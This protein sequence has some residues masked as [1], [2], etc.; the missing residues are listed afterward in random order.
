MAIKGTV[1]SERT[2]GSWGY[3]GTISTNDSTL[4]AWQN[5]VNNNSGQASASLNQTTRVTELQNTLNQAFLDINALAAS[6][7][8]TRPVN[9]TP[10]S[11]NFSNLSLA[12]IN[13]LDTTNGT[14]ET[15]VINVTSW[16][17]SDKILITGDPGDAFIMRWDTDA[18]F[19]DG[20]EGLVKF[21]SGGGIVPLGGL[22]PSSFVHV[23]GAMDA[24]GG[25]TGIG[26][27][28]PYYP[29]SV[30]T[31][32]GFGAPIT[33][34][35]G[36]LD[37]GG[38]FTGYWLSTG[39][40][41]NAPDANHSVRWGSNGSFSNGIFIGGWYSIT[42]NFSM[43]SGTAGVYVGPLDYGDL[44][45]PKYNT[46]RKVTG[47]SG[48]GHVVTD[49]LFM[50]LNFAT[51]IDSE[52]DG[53]PNATATGDDI[54]QGSQIDDETAVTIPTLLAGQNAVF[55]VS[56]TNKTGGNATLYGFIDWNNDGDFADTGETATATVANNT[57]GNVPLTFSVP[58]GAVTGT[59]LGARFRLSTATGLQ[60]TD[61][62][63]TNG[64][65]PAPDG[66]VEDYLVTVQAQATLDFGD[67]PAAAQS[68]F[69]S[70]YPTTLANNGARHTASGPTLGSARD[71]E[72]DGQP[73]ANADGDDTTGTPDDEDGVT[74]P[75]LTQGQSAA[76][77]VNASAA[78]KLDAWIDWNRD[79]DWADAGEQVATNLSVE[80]GNN[81]L[82]V[83]VP[84]GAST[85]TSF[86]RFRLEHR[87]RPDL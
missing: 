80:A 60:A 25:G 7:T 56:V 30:R 11:L 86:A 44:A 68:G 77:T 20:Y 59:N 61:A 70:S 74:I 51:D 82:N 64:P 63:G 38:F 37:Q 58:A 16:P 57:L 87:G 47:T 76:L 78:A 9:G 1:A 19:S 32:N 62:Q 26:E 34:A 83:S 52:G 35:V 48:P 40:P 50:G 15:F 5:I 3:A 43:T 65:I 85:G 21:Q 12:S 2:S 69:A 75:T 73:T 84:A 36:N 41:T 28:Y 33:G 49:S 23:A 72:A 18:N 46:T 22:S 8:Q 67:A 71:A 55:N 29:L 14:A 24:S 45:E 4:G 31:G 13:G 6:P 17:A 42:D 54:V 53:Q 27:L 66:E 79:G 10:T 39:T 81:T